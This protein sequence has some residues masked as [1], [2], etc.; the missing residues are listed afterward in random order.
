MHIRGNKLH[1]GVLR[2]FIAEWPFQPFLDGLTDI[3]FCSYSRHL[4][5]NREMLPVIQHPSP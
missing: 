1:Y 4:L 3:L 2:T 5:L